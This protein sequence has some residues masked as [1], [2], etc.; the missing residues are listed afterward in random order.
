MLLILRIALSVAFALLTGVIDIIWITSGDGM[1]IPGVIVGTST[2]VL[3]LLGF[4]MLLGLIPFALLV[5]VNAFMT[6]VFLGVFDGNPTAG[7][8][9]IITLQWWWV[10]LGLALMLIIAV[11]GRQLAADGR[12]AQRIRV[13]LDRER[14]DQERKRAEQDRIDRQREQELAHAEEVQRI[15]NAAPAA[16]TPGDVTGYEPQ[17]L[18]KIVLERPALMH[19]DPGAGLSSS[20]FDVRR[21]ARGQQGEVNFAKALQK[22]GIHE[23]FASFWSVHM[24]DEEIGASE[25]FTTDIDCIVVTGTTLWLLDMKNYRQGGVIWRVDDSDEKHTLAAIDRVTGGYVGDHKREMSRN[26]AM[27]AA[28]FTT[29]LK[30]V[31]LP[32]EIKS[33]VV[34]MP[35]ADGLGTIEDIFYP[36]NIPAVGLPVLLEWLRAEPAFDPSTEDAKLLT[37]MLSALLK[38]DSGSAIMPA[39]SRGKDALRP[40]DGSERRA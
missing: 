34:M 38:D 9:L 21:V 7:I 8:G 15:K 17:I 4:T 35:Q 27:A 39:T 20:G 37:A 28:R 10:G 5:I 22:E 16:T 30:R 12:E 31:G 23:S 25:T 1:A 11:R 40:V 6:L 18:D 36:G 26:M 24:P 13:Q 14:A 3:I 32:I 2:A 19:G 29:R 33:A